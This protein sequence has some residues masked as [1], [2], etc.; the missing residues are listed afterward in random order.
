MINM[1]R[2]FVVLIG[3]F[4]CSCTVPRDMNPELEWVWILKNE[5]NKDLNIHH[6]L[7]VYSEDY[8]EFDESSEWQILAGQD[9][10][11]RGF[12]RFYNDDSLEFDMFFTFHLE[13]I[14]S[15]RLYI[16]DS[17][18]RILKEW[19]M[20]ADNGEHDIYNENE[21]SCR[22]YKTEHEEIF[23][24]TYIATH[25]EWIFTI[26]DADLVVTE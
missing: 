17:K 1:R 22:Q 20:G 4:L 10:L 26:T 6:E 14:V 23:C 7:I 13:N 3:I 2:L 24:G 18:G 5:T 25:Y 19:V 15:N 8:G 16:T 21:W 12:S 9:K 11:L